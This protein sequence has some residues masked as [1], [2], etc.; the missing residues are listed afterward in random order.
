MSCIVSEVN[1]NK[2]GVMKKESIMF[3]VVGLLIGVII[4][5][6]T[7]GYSV[8]HSN[9]GMMRII[10]VNDSR[11]NSFDMSTNETL[12]DNST[13]M[14]GTVNTLRGKTGD[15][16]DKAF[17]SGMISQQNAKHDEVKTLAGNIITAQTAEI[18]QMKE[19]QLKWGYI[20]SSSGTHDSMDMM[21]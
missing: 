16:F 10:G 4:A 13:S 8:N 5:G 12:D 1:N 14:T 3:G 17:I 18:N 6:G 15:D 21:H 11:I 19:W 2:G 20:K 7:A 9:S